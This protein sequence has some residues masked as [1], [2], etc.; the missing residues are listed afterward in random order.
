MNE[1]ESGAEGFERD[2]EGDRLL[3]ATQGL[4]GVWVAGMD[5]DGRAGIEGRREIRQAHDVVPMHV[6]HEEVEDPG[7]ALGAAAIGAM[8][9]IPKARSHVAD[10]E[11]VV[12]RFDL[13]AG[14]CAAVAAIGREVEIRAGEFRRLGLIA[15]RAATGGYQRVS[16]LGQDDVGMGRHRQRPSGTPETDEH[17]QA[18]QPA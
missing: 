5:N 10:K 3:L 6:G 18:P 14:G 11:G 7:M 9:E 13:D 12:P 15:E 2:G 16:D 1:F 4:F 8:A 17:G